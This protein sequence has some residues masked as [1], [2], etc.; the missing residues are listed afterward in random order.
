V[1]APPDQGPSLPS[2]HSPAFALVPPDLSRGD[3]IPPGVRAAMDGAWQAAGFPARDVTFRAYEDVVV[4]QEGLVLDRDLH[5]IPGSVTQHS[6]A[7]IARG[8]MAAMVARDAEA[9]DPLPGTYVLCKKRGVRNYGHWLLEMLPCAALA[10]EHLPREG[11]RF[12]VPQAEGR[13][14]DAVDAA[15]ARLGLAEDRLLAVGAA[16]ARVERLIMVEGLTQHGV[17]MSPLAPAS[18]RML[19]WDIPPGE[20]RRLFVTRGSVGFR[21][22]ADPAALVRRAE[23]KGY[24]AFDPGT[25]PWLDQVAAF[26]GARR[27]VGVMGAALANIVFAPRGAEVVCL[28]PANM[29]DTFFWFIAGLC[30]L[31]YREIRCE[32]RGP[33]QQGGV[34]DW[35]RE[36]V[37]PEDLA[38]EIFS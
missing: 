24:R 38:D 16:P 1:T 25:V 14:A 13:L 23:V 7:E 35:D 26:A 21:D 20:A 2:L 10:W 3:L 34:A 4:V 29:P 28:A 9:L 17:F 15:L 32:V 5:P 36:M 33:V 11:L 8:R 22:F 6:P 18:A 30:G 12:V 31:R 27:I 37:F 19:A